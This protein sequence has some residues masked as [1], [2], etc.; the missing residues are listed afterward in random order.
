MPI[1]FP[2][3]HIAAS[4]VNRILNAADGLESAAPGRPVS[5]PDVPDTF[6]QGEQL[7]SAL[8]APIAPLPPIDEAPAPGKTLAG[9]PLL[10]TVLEPQT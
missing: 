8:A 3:M 10:S 9:T 1:K 4:V 7:D 2:R 5:P 6:L